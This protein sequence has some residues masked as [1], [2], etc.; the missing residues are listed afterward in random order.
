[1]TTPEDNPSYDAA[2]R[3]PH[4]PLWDDAC[5]AEIENFLRYLT[6][7]ERKWYR[8]LRPPRR[9]NRY[10]G[11]FGL[12]AGGGSRYS[13]R[14]SPSRVTITTPSKCSVRSVSTVACGGLAK[15]KPNADGVVQES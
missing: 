1:M 10:V 3:G 2:Q 4:K 5:D 11:R 9:L 15:R 14:L 13:H 8:P 6:L 7:W 12:L